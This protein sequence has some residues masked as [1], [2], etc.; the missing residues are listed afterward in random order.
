VI[1]KEKVMSGNIRQA[2]YIDIDETASQRRHEG[3][4]D[5]LNRGKSRN[6][7]TPAS[8]EEWAEVLATA[9]KYY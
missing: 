4:N 2:S 1:D 8:R 6:C 3:D 7:Q 5:L 9:D